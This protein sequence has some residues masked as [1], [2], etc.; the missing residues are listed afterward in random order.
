MMLQGLNDTCCIHGLN[1]TMT[2]VSVIRVG[3]R[4]GR[5]AWCPVSGCAPPPGGP[6]HGGRAAEPRGESGGAR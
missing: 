2:R 3:G 4:G 6:S 5:L 1:D